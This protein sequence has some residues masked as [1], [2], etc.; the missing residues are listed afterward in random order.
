MSDKAF[1]LSKTE[2]G[3]LASLG[4]SK[5]LYCF[6]LNMQEGLEREELI[7][8]IYQ[9][10]KNDWGSLNDQGMELCGTMK[11]LIDDVVRAETLLDVEGAEE[12]S[13]CY[14]GGQAV[15]LTAVPDGM[16]RA[17]GLLYDELLSWIEET[18]SLGKPFWNTEEEALEETRSNESVEQERQALEEGRWKTASRKGEIL[19]RNAGDG[20]VTERFLFVQ[21]VLNL[22]LIQVKEDGEVIRIT[23]DSAEERQRLQKRWEELSR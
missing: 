20:S 13:L 11:E 21:G 17:G 15:S 23:P 1:Y 8:S 9:I 22:W 12:R 7:Q 18:L 4:G 16:L 10:V 2:F 5:K 3:V 6:D 14:L 19:L